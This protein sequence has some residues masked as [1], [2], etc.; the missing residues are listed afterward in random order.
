M[1]CIKCGSE[2]IFKGKLATGTGGLIFT[3]EKSLKK[4]PLT[5][6]YSTLTAMGCKDCGAVF[7]IQME[8]PRA[9]DENK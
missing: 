1:K 7:D 6:N 8:N 9:I 2:N 3:T 4:L 5:Q